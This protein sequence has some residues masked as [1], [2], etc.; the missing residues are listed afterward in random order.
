MYKV[1]GELTRRNRLKVDTFKK[2][3]EVDGLL[4]ITTTKVSDFE[5]K[6]LNNIS[7][8]KKI[9]YSMVI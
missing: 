6:L 4:D 8:I 2:F 3:D 5:K 7:I 1:D 9:A